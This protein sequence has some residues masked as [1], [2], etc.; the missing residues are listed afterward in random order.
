MLWSELCSTRKLTANIHLV[1][2]KMKPIVGLLNECEVLPCRLHSPGS[3][4][5]VIVHARTISGNLRSGSLRYRQ[6]GVTLGSYFVM[7]RLSVHHSTRL[8]GVKNATAS[9]MQTA[10][11]RLYLNLPTQ[12]LRTGPPIQKTLKLF[13]NNR[14]RS[15][16][17][18][19]SRPD[20]KTS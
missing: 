14:D 5:L 13:N 20:P 11:I 18:T 12:S 9:L 2:K 7:H 16:L 10:P 1:P 8:D 19:G 4:L 17:Q 15:P 3:P 6:Y